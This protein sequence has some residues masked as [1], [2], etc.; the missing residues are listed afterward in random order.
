MFF[1]CLFFLI[2]LRLSLS[3]HSWISE[4][5]Y[6]ALW[7]WTRDSS[8]S[9]VFS[10]IHWNKIFSFTLQM[11]I[12][13]LKHQGES[14]MN[15]LTF[16][17][18]KCS[19]LFY[20][21]SSSQWVLAPWCR[22]LSIRLCFLLVVYSALLYRK[23]TDPNVCFLQL[24]CRRLR[25]G[26]LSKLVLQNS[27]QILFHFNLKYLNGFYFGHVEWICLIGA[28]LFRV[29]LWQSFYLSK[30]FSCRNKAPFRS[31]LQSLWISLMLL[32]PKL[33][34]VIQSEFQEYGHTLI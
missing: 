4:I 26:F 1:R 24:M 19:K 34:I 2:D 31:I 17:K 32:M 14:M 22:L 12:N 3:L 10:C 7:S 15:F 25:F 33:N 8:P 23:A 20:C 27:S 13:T 18:S 9:S 21:I 29:V 6:V 5:H 30:R 11:D 28:V 16:Y